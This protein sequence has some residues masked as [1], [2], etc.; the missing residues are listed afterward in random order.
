MAVSSINCQLIHDLLYK[1]IILTLYAAGCCCDL[2]SHLRVHFWNQILEPFINDVINFSPNF[3]PLSKVKLISLK[4]QCWEKAR[5]LDFQWKVLHLFRQKLFLKSGALHFLL[6]CFFSNE[7]NKVKFLT[8]QNPS[9][10]IYFSICLFLFKI[11]SNFV[12]LA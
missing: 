8:T 10:Y 4:I 11:L 7:A 1:K 3:D 12:F 5:N 2:I 6:I 9:I